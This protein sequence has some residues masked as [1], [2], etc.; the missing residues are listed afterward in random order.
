MQQG[1]SVRTIVLGAAFVA[2]Y[3]C[4]DLVSQVGIYRT[5]GVSPWS[6]SAG[7]ALAVAYIWGR[8][9]WPYM[10]VAS[11]LAL[12]FV[13]PLHLSLP[14]Q[15]IMAI[16]TTG[17]WI[18]AGDSLRRLEGFDPALSTLRSVLVLFSVAC[19]AS[20]LQTICYIG[21]LRMMALLSD[22]TLLPTGWRFLVGDLVGIL[23]ATPLLLLIH[24]KRN[25]PMPDEVHL[26]QLFVLIGALIVIFGVPGAT[27]YQLFYLL[28]L[29]V[30]WV[31]LRDGIAGSVLVLNACQI[32]II[33]GADY[34]IS[35]TPGLGALQTMMIVLL[36]TGLL[37][38]VTVTEGQAAAQRL[39]DQQAALNRALRLRSAG[40]TAAAIAHQINQ[41]LTAISTY[42]AV[43]SDAL[44]SGNTAT[45]KASM[46]KLSSECDR[47]AAVLRSI[48]DLVKLGGLTRAPVNL[49]AVLAELSQLLAAECTAKR[50]TLDMNVSPALPM[51]YCDR[52]QLQQALYNLINNSIEAIQET[53]RSGQV[54]VVAE[55][56]GDAVT[57]DVSDDGPGFAPGLEELVAAPFTTTKANGSGLGLAIARSVAE[58]HGG[59]LS[60]VPTHRG[61]TVRLMLPMNRVESYVESRQ[62]H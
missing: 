1:T 2:A 28:F 56:S 11:L 54:R 25:W 32:G 53:G 23:A 43:A 44:D 55:Y 40:E 59:S 62:Y 24:A 34:R 46:A 17:I 18:A 12:F 41:P 8:A 33:C 15:L 20:A 3:L 5:V 57:L 58:A 10:L 30:L 51:L 6:P 38:G 16:A 45:A 61:A 47:A 7:L 52:V 22:A 60:I 35:L 50:V 39:R 9:A 31:A 42:A 27:S 21:T 48:R 13:H 4:L 14:L 19:A 49:Q 26:L 37:I 29:P 36:I